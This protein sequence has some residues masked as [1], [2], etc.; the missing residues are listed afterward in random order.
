MKKNPKHS[1]KSRHSILAALLLTVPGQ[2]LYMSSMAATLPVGTP[3][4]T[5]SSPAKTASKSIN[6]NLSSTTDSVAASKAGTI[7]L[8]GHLAP[9][10]TVSGGTPLAVALGQLITPAMNAA[11]FQ[12]LGGS[13]HLLLN[14][15]G[16]ATAGV[17][18]INSS[19]AGSVSSLVIPSGV[20]VDAVG[21]NAAKPLNVSG[22]S[23]VNG[24][25]YALQ[26]TRGQTATLNFGN[27]LNVGANGLVSSNMPSNQSLTGLYASH[28]L[29][30]NV[31]GDLN[32]SGRIAS[33]GNLNLS[34]AGN[35]NNCSV[36]GQSAASISAQNLN[37]VSGTGTIVNSGS[38]SAVNTLNIN[39]TIPTTNLFINNAGG[40]IAATGGLDPSSGAVQSGVI[41]LRFNGPDVESADVTVLGG[42]LDA[43]GGINMFGKNMT[44]AVEQMIGPVNN[45]GS[46]AHLSVNG[47]NLEM[48]VQ[49][50]TG[51][52]TYYNTNGSVTIGDL[53]GISGNIIIVASQD[54]D[55][56][57]AG[58]QTVID[59]SI[60]QS[61]FI[62]AGLNFTASPDN[63]QS[64]YADNSG[65]SASTTLSNFT[66]GSGNINGG[67][68]EVNIQTA[69]T[70][71]IT[72]VA[73]ANGQPNEGQV[74]LGAVGQSG[75][76]I[77][78]E[79]GNIL[80]IGEGGVNIGSNPS[81]GTIGTASGNVT[82]A[83]ATFSLTGLSFST[84][85]AT[86]TNP[87]TSASIGTATNSVSVG[88]SSFAAISTTGGVT[89]GS[90]TILAK[91]GIAMSAIEN[92]N[93]PNPV[94]L[95]T[96]SGGMAFGGT[97]TSGVVTLQSDN[98][99]TIS[100]EITSTQTVTIKT[101]YLFI[102]ELGAITGSSV[103][104]VPSPNNPNSDLNIDASGS[105][106]ATNGPINITSAPGYNL[107][108]YKSQGDRGQQFSANGL[109]TLTATPSAS[110]ANGINFLNDAFGIQFSTATIVQAGG[111]LQ[112]IYVSSGA[113]VGG[114]STLN[115]ESNN[116]VLQGSISGS[117]LV[118]SPGGLGTIVN[119]STSS[120]NLSTAFPAGLHFN[121]TSLA[122]LSQGNI[123][124]SRPITIDLSNSSGGFAGQLTM[125]AGFTAYAGLSGGTLFPDN[126]VST[127]ILNE[128]DFSNIIGSA[129]IDIPSVSINTGAGSGGTGGNVFIAASGSVTVGPINTS[130]S[131]LSPSSMANLGG[132]VQ[133]VGNGISV[134]A[135]T[136]VGIVQSGAVQLNSGGI[137]LSDPAGSHGFSINNGIMF[138]GFLYPSSPHGNIVISNINAG[139]NGN[140][141]LT[142]GGVG[143]FIA[144]AGTAITCGNL[145]AL[146]GTGNITLRVNATSL[147]LNGLGRNPAVAGD[148]TTTF[149]GVIN[150]TDTVPVTVLGVS[151]ANNFYNAISLTV[152]D[153]AGITLKGGGSLGTLVLNSTAP[154]TASVAN[155]INFVGATFSVNGNTTVTDSGPLNTDIISVDNAS[156]LSG[157]VS[158]N[159]VQGVSIGVS[160]GC[161]PCVQVNAGTLNIT[162]SKG[163][164]A[165]ADN[166]VLSSRTGMSF[167]APEGGISFGNG[168]TVTAGGALINPSASPL[169]LTTAM[170][171]SR[172]SLTMS[173]G[174]STGIS[175]NGTGDIFTVNGG[176]MTV[177]ATK[178]GIAF[179][180]GTGI[181][182]NGG[183]L[184]MTASGGNLDIGTTGA[185]SSTITVRQL[186]N[187]YGSVVLTGF[188]GINTAPN[189]SITAGGTLEMVATVSVAS[190]IA[191]SLIG[192]GSNIQAHSSVI[193]EAEGSQSTFSSAGAISSGVT[194]AGG[195]NGVGELEAISSGKFVL[196]TAGLIGGS[197][198]S[199][200]STLL[201]TST[202][203]ISAQ[204]GA[205]IVA[206]KG[207]VELLSPNQITLGSGASGAKVQTTGGN[208]EI[209]IE[210][211]GV[212]IEKSS[213]LSAAGLLDVINDNT[214]DSLSI[215]NSVQIDSGVAKT[216][217]MTLSSNGDSNGAC[218]SIG[219]GA[220]F[221]SQDGNITI[222]GT[223]ATGT[224]TLGDAYDLT[225]NEGSVSISTLCGVTGSGTGS[226][227]SVGSGTGT[228]TSSITAT[229]VGVVG[230]LVTLSAS[231]SLFTGA[232][233]VNSGASTSITTSRSSLEVSGTAISAATTGTIRGVTG[234]TLDTAASAKSLNSLSISSIGVG[235]TLTINGATTGATLSAGELNNS[236]APP[237]TGNLDNAP[238]SKPILENGTLTLSAPI[239]DLA[240]ASSSF[241]SNGG[242]VDIT[243]TGVGVGTGTL[244]VGA[245]NTFS[246]NGG[247]IQLLAK[248]NVAGGTGDIFN[249]RSVGN[250]ANAATNI[251]G[252]VE[253]GSGLT[254]SSNV[255][256]ALASVP[257]SSAT[258]ST[259]ET[260]IGTTNVNIGNAPASSPG[261]LKVTISGLSSTIN[262]NGSILNFNANPNTLGSQGGAQV[263]DAEGN[264][265]VQFGAG[266]T[267]NTAAL[268]PISMVSGISTAEQETALQIQE[269][270]DG[271]GSS[272]VSAGDELAVLELSNGVNGTSVVEPVV[273]AAGSLSKPA[274]KL[275]S[276]RVFASP[277]SSFVHHK[278]GS[279]D[280][281]RGELCVSALQPAGIVSNGVTV[282]ANAGGIVSVKSIQG[283]TYVRACSSAGTVAVKINGTT[284]KLNAGEEMIVTAHKP[285]RTELR[286]ADGISRRNLR[287]M[288]VADRYVALCDFAIISMLSNGGALVGLQHS[289]DSTNKHLLSRMLKTAATVDTV[290]NY[291]G[292]YEAAN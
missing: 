48:G 187:V 243:A 9:N 154:S 13:Q 271:T 292:A 223:N 281:S 41:N 235:S 110:R 246:A 186:N 66:A 193:I 28:D 229:K 220:A 100:G 176:S 104:V 232:G 291:R 259:L 32:N 17:D 62:G 126:Q 266:T 93:D 51:D 38:L 2:S 114:S 196:V 285:D 273:S 240:S 156:T 79:N 152:T 59:A 148:L 53:E 8:G 241:T 31:G 242:N 44:A 165:I 268:K 22:P 99:V 265:S 244:T 37:L 166:V 153:P 109:I 216:G 257:T 29:S 194:F 1:L 213:Q 94:T 69:G 121:G 111:Q 34:V 91:T 81:G 279:I 61:I 255:L 250:P 7:H 90:A 172:G 150:I 58:N 178:G 15:L 135:I 49:N 158:L 129:S 202:G 87:L 191:T 137:S 251:G 142:T 47:G 14:N 124:S 98:G 164:I 205:S 225:A 261:V 203:G 95:T 170:L 182:V 227:L 78:N 128:I 163:S 209:L 217:S 230:G 57:H 208:F 233:S 197:L 20:T 247:N 237:A 214:K 83:S 157:N 263:F 238:G 82:I 133:I 200:G 272:L 108:I 219:T 43:P 207:I 284:I 198:T 86:I 122:I 248:S 134:G 80:I 236:P 143:E 283:N 55:F 89:G 6:L 160:G 210:S 222:S 12:A 275:R 84:N 204:D 221:T 256:V 33:S 113:G 74:N 177:S 73:S 234:V 11:L 107:N 278:D 290:L 146:N 262:L 136:T 277:R 96:Q 201:V 155:Q 60:N 112:S 149:G 161:S 92:Q 70:G 180:D 77:S 218:I 5:S 75:S 85:G 264:T 141:T 139:N 231:G 131:P 270:G 147:S 130:S 54:I 118:F 289:N 23:T 116:L 102:D 88:P 39:T 76:T 267:F 25:M 215:G 63:S 67:T 159:G 68:S 276:A 123:I 206:N 181:N 280:L 30:L 45:T 192:G 24:S 195:P 127:G 167:S 140:V 185:T 171:G 224:V 258:V 288:Q 26:T 260:K 175:S 120:L 105:F 4:H 253:V 115:L 144:V 245:T 56:A 212:N 184:T 52:P 228:P 211:A 169:S 50:L 254:V 138:N 249:A 199:N 132:N 42:V 40:T 162:S 71:T 97:D 3:T 145:S 226:A 190:P 125:L 18:K 189:T 64:S 173:A 269:Q 27:D 72:I 21:Y 35:L 106:V 19:W 101:S 282:L 10:G 36:G 65:G 119:T 179:G 151:G 16:A 117:P 287:T 174:G 46:A 274:V 286:P 252:G 168:V 188:N 239:V 103:T 183:S